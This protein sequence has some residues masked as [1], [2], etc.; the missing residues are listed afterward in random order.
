MP[1]YEVAPP[2]GRILEIE[3]NQPPSEI[4][5]DDIFASVGSTKQPTR[6]KKA[7][8]DLTPSGLIN[9]FTNTVSSGLASPIVALKEGL[10]INEAYD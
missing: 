1:T 7:G 5:R 10:P 3:E 2:D 8:V 6:P 4:E 9:Q